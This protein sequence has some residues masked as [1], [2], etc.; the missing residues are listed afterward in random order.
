MRSFTEVKNLF[1]FSCLV[2]YVCVFCN[3]ISSAFNLILV[4]L[5]NILAPNHLISTFFWLVIYTVA[6]IMIIWH[7]TALT[8]TYIEEK[9]ITVLSFDTFDNMKHMLTI[10][11][12]VFLDP[13]KISAAPQTANTTDLL[14]LLKNA[15]NHNNSAAD[16]SDLVIRSTQGQIYFMTRHHKFFFNR[17]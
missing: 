2:K 3:F 11:N 1:P 16:D 5:K 6:S 17:A 10:C 4:T 14:R 7:C 12:D 8:S 13:H 15:I 9:T